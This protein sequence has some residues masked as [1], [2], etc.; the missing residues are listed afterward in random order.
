MENIPNQKKSKI[1]IAK[2]PRVFKNERVLIVVYENRIEEYTP[3]HRY[4]K[5]EI[6]AENPG[7]S[8]SY[9]DIFGKGWNAH[10]EVEVLKDNGFKEV[11]TDNKLTYR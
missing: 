9:E 3:L 7:C 10:H 8:Y 5:S 4:S 2:F 6:D 11:H 1:S